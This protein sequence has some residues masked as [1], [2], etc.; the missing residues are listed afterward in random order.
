MQ[1]L[2]IP[3]EHQQHTHLHNMPELH[4]KNKSHTKMKKN[5]M[6]KK[7]KLIT[8]TCHHN[9]IERHWRIDGLRLD[10]EWWECKNCGKILRVKE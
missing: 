6:E 3:M 5:A 9:T 4:K 10:A 7:E 1:Q 8:G 2:P